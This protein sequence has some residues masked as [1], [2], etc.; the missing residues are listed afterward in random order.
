MG[1]NLNENILDYSHTL[2][3]WG[4][5]KD[6]MKCTTKE[7]QVALKV[8]QKRIE[9][10]DFSHRLGFEDYNKEQIGLF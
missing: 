7:I 2:T 9:S 5:W 3:K 10:L 1:T 8:S 6:I 4:E